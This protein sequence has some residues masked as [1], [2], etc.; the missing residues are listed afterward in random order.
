MALIAHSS[1]TFRAIVDAGVVGSVDTDSIAEGIAT[2]ALRAGSC[3]DTEDTV[4]MAF[5]AP[6]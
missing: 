6:S 1:H 3:I 2:F 5:E 4:C